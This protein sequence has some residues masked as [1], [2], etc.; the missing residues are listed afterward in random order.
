[1]QLHKTH[2]HT[3]YTHTHTLRHK[4][5]LNYKTYFRLFF[6]EFC[7]LAFHAMRTSVVKEP[8]TFHAFN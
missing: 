8:L 3:H 4:V 7:Q 2:S 6:R 1:M 5:D